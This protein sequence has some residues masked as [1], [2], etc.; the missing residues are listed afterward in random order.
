MKNI[1][2]FSFLMVW[3]FVQAQKQITTGA[4]T[5]G[6][7]GFDMNDPKSKEMN[8]PQ[9]LEMF[10][11]MMKYT[12]YFSPEHQKMNTDVMNGMSRTQVY[13]D[14]NGSK[15]VTYM[16]MMGKKYKILNQVSQLSDTSKMSEIEIKYDKADT[17]KILDFDCY[18]ATI[19]IKNIPVK[20]KKSPT[21]LTM[22]CYLTDQ[23]APSKLS[24][25]YYG[26]K[27]KGFPLE[28]GIDA[29]KMKMIL[30]ATAIRENV[31]PSEFTEPNGYQ[32][33]TK[34][35]FE[36]EIGKGFNKN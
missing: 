30:A 9:T 28:F 35:E 14:V 32:E 36:K 18:K 16:D 23:I 19:T 15:S 22:N 29:Q 10:K 6:I 31:D 20:D 8:N 21:E 33:I 12:I 34:E 17:K 1:L 5:F 11:N 3:N 27:L 26:G 13:Y 2:I 25:N 7:V 4:I 24:M